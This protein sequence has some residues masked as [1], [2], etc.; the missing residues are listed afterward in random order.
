MKPEDQKVRFK[1]MPGMGG[2]IVHVPKLRGGRPTRVVPDKTKYDR[3][4]ERRRFR[5]MIPIANILRRVMAKSGVEYDAFS[6]QVDLPAELGQNINAWCQRITDIELYDNDKH[7]YGRENDFH[8][9]LLYGIKEQS[10]EKV[11]KLLKEFRPFKVRLGLVTAFRDKAEYD[12]LK[13][14]AEAPELHKIHYLLA[15][16]LKNEHSFPTYAPHMTLCYL[17]K[18]NVDKY[19]GDNT[20]QGASFFVTDIKFCL[21]D[22]SKLSLRLGAGL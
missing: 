3:K 19:L 18:G 12:V 15:D 5:E 10:P 20:F 13:L 7:E 1:D 14:D 9:T 2:G 22:S 21:K 4:Q 16:N 8:I 6:T 11:M 17:K